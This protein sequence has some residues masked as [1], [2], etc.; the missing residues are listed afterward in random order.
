MD[1]KKILMVEDDQDFV[2]LLAMALRA[3]QY[4][5]T[6]AGDAI[7]AVSEAKKSRPDVILLDIG[8]PAGDGLVVMERLNKTPGVSGTPIIVVSARDPATNKDHAIQCGAFAYFQK[9]A[10]QDELLASIRQALEEI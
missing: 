7:T 4:E 5:I 2:R 8:L 6:I 10:D 1:N 9:P 3:Q